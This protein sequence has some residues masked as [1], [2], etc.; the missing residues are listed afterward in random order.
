MKA[1]PVR[2]VEGSGYRQCSVEEA[3]HI[4]LRLP[5]PTTMNR[6]FLP[7]IIKGRREG[8][9]C[10]TWNGST[11]LPT[12]RPSVLTTAG[13]FVKGF[14]PEKD[15]CWCKY[16]EQRPNEK[17]QFQCFRCHSWINAGLVQFLDDCSHELRNQTL[18]LLE[19]PTT[20]L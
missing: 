3:T 10:W 9:G 5:G 20:D 13:H 15:F 17:V 18:A 1:V 14:D 4:G 19:I 2:S 8:T 7:V 16:N 12:L 11:D 6:L